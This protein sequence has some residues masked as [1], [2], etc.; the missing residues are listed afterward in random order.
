MN[1]I[2]KQIGAVTLLMALMMLLV[3]S[4]VTFA[5]GRMAVD[6]TRNARWEN[7][8]AIAYANAVMALS[9]ALYQIENGSIS[10]VSGANYTAYFCDPGD[11]F[12]VSAAEGCGSLQFGSSFNYLTE[13]TWSDENRRSIILAEGVSSDAADA[14][15]Q[16]IVATASYVKEFG[17]NSDTPLVSG[18]VVDVTGSATLVN[19][20]GRVTVWSGGEADVGNGS[21]TELDTKILAPQYSYSDYVNGGTSTVTGTT[22]GK[23][24]IDIVDQDSNLKSLLEDSDSEKLFKTFFGMSLDD[25]K[26]LDGIE[27]ITDQTFSPLDAKDQISGRR[28]LVYHSGNLSMPSNKVFGSEGFPVI[29]IVDGNL[30]WSN[31]SCLYGIVFVSGTL[32][33]QGSANGSSDSGKSCADDEGN[34]YKMLGSMIVKDEADLSGGFGIYFDKVKLGDPDDWIQADIVAGGW[35]DWRN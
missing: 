5:I 31:N 1:N 21:S 28:R 2:R 30:S 12:G 24:G 35:K 4:A 32:T 29:L 25:W 16:Y 34:K 8:R 26:D 17:N 14:A 18:S 27:D 6:E 19:R 9:D 22:G 7:D 33:G 3:I 20:G 13:K 10:T 23:K 15:K 11:N